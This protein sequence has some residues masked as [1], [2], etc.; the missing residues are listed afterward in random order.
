[1]TDRYALFGNPI[2]HSKSP[3]IH[4]LFAEQTGEDIAYEKQLVPLGEFADAARAFF[5]AGGKG[6]NV[7]V[8]FKQDAYELADSRSSQARAAGAVNT[9][10]VDATGAISGYNTDGIGLVHDLQQH[11]NRNLNGAT[12]L[13]LGAGGAVRGVIEPLLDCKPSQVVISNRTQNKAEQLARAFAKRGPVRAATIQ[14]LHQHCFDLVINGTSASLA[15]DLPELQPS[16]VG[17]GTLCY[18]MVY[19]DEPTA[20]MRW[21]LERGAQAADGL[22]MLVA[23]AAESFHI[24]RGVRPDVAAVIATLRAD[25]LN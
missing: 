10:A 16:L 22:G 21:G 15:G 1:M 18:D 25:M 12:I 9:L 20:F 7:T 2:A 14:D 24:W 19:A 5:A 3:R 17:P 6:L 8:P 4:R 11:L 23:Q 13:L